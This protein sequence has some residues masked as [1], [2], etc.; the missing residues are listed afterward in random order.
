MFPIELFTKH[1]RF[2]GILGFASNLLL[3]YMAIKRTSPAFR[4]YSY[5]ILITCVN[6]LIYSIV[7]LACGRVSF[8]R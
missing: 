4:N 6:D 2:M 1:D 5:M 8:L 3:F 7:S